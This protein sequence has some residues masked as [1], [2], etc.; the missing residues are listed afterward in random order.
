MAN[1]RRCRGIPPGWISSVAGQI[2][3]FLP[4]KFPAQNKFYRL[5]VYGKSA[6]ALYSKRAAAPHWSCPPMWFEET[7]GGPISC[8]HRMTAMAES[9][10]GSRVTAHSA[11]KPERGHYG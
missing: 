8:E 5:T 4:R 7:R 9:A 11:S 6:H 2:G 10:K 3:D 1:N